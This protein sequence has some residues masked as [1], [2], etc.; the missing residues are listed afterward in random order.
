MLDGLHED[1]N[2]VKVKPIV[3]NKDYELCDDEIVSKESWDNYLKRNQSI[4]VDHFA[5]QFKST[6]VCPDCNRISVTF[7]PFLIASLPIPSLDY[8][9]LLIYLFFYES[10]KTPLKLKLN[11][12]SF[13]NVDTLL[14]RIGNFYKIDDQHLE[15]CRIKNFVI[16]EFIPRNTLIIKLRDIEG[17]L[18]VYEKFAP[19]PQLIYEPEHFANVEIQILQKFAKKKE[20]FTKEVGF[21][22]LY[23]ISLN[24]SL[25]QFHLEIYKTLRENIKNMYKLLAKWQVSQYFAK[26]NF[27]TEERQKNFDPLNNLE[28]EYREIFLSEKKELLPPYNIF[29]LKG[30]NEANLTTELIPFDNATL[31]SILKGVPPN[32]H[33][34]FQIVFDG[35]VKVEDIKLTVCFPDNDHKNI[36]DT[37]KK[38]FTIQECFELFTRE[39]K[40]DKENEWY[41]NKCKGHKQATKK[42]ELYKLPD[43]LILHLKRFKTSRI[44]SFGSIYFPAGSTKI[45]S[46]VEFP[47]EEINLDEFCKKKNQNCKYQLIGVSNHYGEMG[48]G[49][50]TAYCRNH[51]TNKWYEFDDASVSTAK[52]DEVVSQ[53]AYMLFYQKI[54]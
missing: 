54:N 53:A 36:N 47:I 26:H 11:L 17:V 46:F 52:Q 16:R 30:K 14:K 27:E 23:E 41:C 50:Y 1:L 29:M 31:K 35:Y 20:N 32:Q 25:I 24:I 6:I 40:L 28:A 38:S 22:R 44:G 2:R 5:G 18:F 42:M 33:I 43:V 34:K 8:T 13:I 15:M 51:F 37:I 48:G 3:E 21:S 9:P 12:F 19:S 45:N 10:K 49:H 4:I 39:E 7:D